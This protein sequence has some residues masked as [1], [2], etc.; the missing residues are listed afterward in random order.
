MKGLLMSIVAGA[1]MA[2][3]SNVYAAKA[4]PFGVAYERALSENVARKVNI[5]PVSYRL[6]GC[7]E[8]L[9]AGGL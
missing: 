9:F 1:V 5:R 4:N 2:G 6:H 7:R 8:H 3:A